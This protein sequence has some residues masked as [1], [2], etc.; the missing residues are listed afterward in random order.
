MEEQETHLPLPKVRGRA[1]M[2]DPHPEGNQH[3]APTVTSVPMHPSRPCGAP[4]RKFELRAPAA[5]TAARAVAH[6]LTQVRMTAATTRGGTN[7][8]AL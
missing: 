2:E 3:K 7:A 1:K 8:G 6:P 4:T 5:A